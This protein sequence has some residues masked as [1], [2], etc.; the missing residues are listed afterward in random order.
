MMIT[1]AEFC[2]QCPTLTGSH[3]AEAAVATVRRWALTGRVVIVKDPNTLIE[4][5]D[6]T[7]IA[8]EARRLVYNTKLAAGEIE[9][10]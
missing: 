5:I 8:L 1:L 4:T 3:S 7:Y 9:A 2:E 10:P 6:N